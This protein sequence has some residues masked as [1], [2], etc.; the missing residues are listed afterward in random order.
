VWFAVG[1]A[2]FATHPAETA[3]LYAAKTRALM[4]TGPRFILGLGLDELGYI[5]PT[6]YFDAPAEYLHAT[7]LTSMSPG[8]DAGSAMMSALATVIP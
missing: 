7:Y 4:D 5:C 6:A 8:R 1:S 2:Q 3:P